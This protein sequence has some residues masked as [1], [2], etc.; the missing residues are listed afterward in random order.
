MR[1]LVGALALAVA[2]AVLAAPAS[3]ANAAPFSDKICPEASQSVTALGALS[4]SEAQKVSEA[5]HAASAVYETCA[6]RNLS[7]GNNQAAHYGYTRQASY[8]LIEA[9]A[10]L[11]LNRT[12]DAKAVIENSKHVA[13]EVFDWIGYGGGNSRVRSMYRP[14]A[15]EVLDD[16]NEMLAKLKAAAVATAAPAAPQPTTKP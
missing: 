3:R 5:A 13:S 4:T 15:K 8:Q 7:D 11:A 12:S 14:A 6:K 1:L 16:A 10:L 9:R 2:A